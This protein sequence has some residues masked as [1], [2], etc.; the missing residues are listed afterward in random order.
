MNRLIRSLILSL[1]M[2]ASGNVFSNP[3][4]TSQ[5]LKD[6]IAATEL[7]SAFWGLE[8]RDAHTDECLL[9][10]HSHK[11]FIPA[12]VTKLFTSTASL[13]SLG[14]G[15][16]FHTNVYATAPSNDLGKIQGN[17]ILKGGGDPT[18]VSSD[19]KTLAQRIHAL[20]IHAIEGNVLVDNSHFSG[21]Q[22]IPHSEW[23]DLTWHDSPE[24]SALTLNENAIF[25]KLSSGR[26]IGKAAVIEV[27]QDIPYVTISSD[28]ITVSENNTTGHSLTVSRGFSDNHL[29]ISGT[30]PINSEEIILKTALH[31]PDEYAR[32]VFIRELRQAGITI[33][34]KN[35]EHQDRA[36]Q[37]LA[38]HQS[39]ALKDILKIIN[40][41]SH[42]LA[43]ELVFK[44]ALLSAQNNPLNQLI[45]AI[46]IEGG[47]FA[48]YSGSGL[49]M[50]NC[51]T[52][53][54]VCSL[55]KYLRASQSPIID[56]LPIAGV[57]GSLKERFRGTFGEKNIRAK[58]G[59]LK[60]VSALA[61]YATTKKGRDICFSVF[62]N[63]YTQEASFC[64]QAI[65]EL[66]LNILE[67]N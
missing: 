34:E 25:L 47:N 16:R 22:L 65:D 28:L 32:L 36:L 11:N 21:N 29:S 30:I 15:Y 17:I 33:E 48:L 67:Q 27:E 41:N 13:M 63:H 26:E 40:K 46:K 61:G 45:D 23:E 18:L 7:S 24:I 9:G 35:C 39:A 44:E 58:T 3:I 60:G 56:S 55:L 57:D 54:D 50:H 51:L 14:S 52:P 31:R 19:L 37:L 8:V 1:L 12:S 59:T 2:L 20:G 64:R 49:S 6:Y 38:R 66:L 42:N 10:Y 5:Q 53:S 43:A 62:V 4:Y